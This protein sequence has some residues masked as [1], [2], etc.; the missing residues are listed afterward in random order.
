MRGIADQSKK[1]KITPPASTDIFDQHTESN[2][3]NA[4]SVKHHFT[5]YIDIYSYTRTNNT[6]RWSRYCIS[7][8]T[9][10]PKGI[11][12]YMSDRGYSLNYYSS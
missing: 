11:T 6:D 8:E 7:F 3:Y 1:Y 12:K 9:L 2:L 4:S 5:L 10:M